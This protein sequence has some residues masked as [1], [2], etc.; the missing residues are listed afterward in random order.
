MDHD[1]S[2]GEYLRARRELVRPED[3]GIRAGNLRRVAGLR[4]EEVAMLAGISS[5]YYLRLEQG[6]DSNPSMQV[7]EALAQVLRLDAAGTAYLITLG[8]PRARSAKRP[9]REVVPT[10]IRQLLDSIGLPAFVEGRYL[11]VLASNPLARALAPTLVE[12]NNRLRDFFLDPSEQ[13]LFIDWDSAVTGLVAGFRDAVGTD[14]GDPRFVQLV[15][16]LSL[17]SDVFRRAW[18]RQDVRVRQG[19]E[20]RMRHPQVGD[21]ALRREKLEITGTD[22]LMLVMYHAEPHSESAGLLALLGSLAAPEAVPDDVSD[23]VSEPATGAPSVTAT[24]EIGDH[25]ADEHRGGGRPA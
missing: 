8:Q 12:G 11:D 25:L 22:G 14:T 13:D 19:G 21:L 18:A 5:D 17:A 1:N 3:V 23:D 4:R 7:L 2:L 24:D 15:G 10:G 9:R 20:V 6:R 16:E